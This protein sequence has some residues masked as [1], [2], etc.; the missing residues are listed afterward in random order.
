MITT[1]LCIV[2]HGNKGWVSFSRITFQRLREGIAKC[3]CIASS[4]HNIFHLI[5]DKVHEVDRCTLKSRKVTK[6]HFFLVSCLLFFSLSFFLSFFLYMEE[7]FL[8]FL[9]FLFLLFFLLSCVLLFFIFFSFL[10]F[11]YL[12]IYVFN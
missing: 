8:S 9:C 6:L 1:K 3:Y 11:V 4:F 12:Y 2:Y 5:H 10:K 7:V